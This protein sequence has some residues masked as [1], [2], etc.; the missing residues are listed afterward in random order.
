[1]GSVPSD[2]F[3]L[4]GFP[5]DYE[6]SPGGPRGD[7]GQSLT[8]GELFSGKGICYKWFELLGTPFPA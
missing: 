4:D 7:V 2:A 1:M 6:L 8:S 3:E 5:V